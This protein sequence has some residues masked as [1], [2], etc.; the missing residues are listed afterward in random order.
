MNE[1]SWKEKFTWKPSE[2]R[3]C[4]PDVLKAMEA[5]RASGLPTTG[6]TVAELLRWAAEQRK[7]DGVKCEKAVWFNN[8]R[9]RSR[10]PRAKQADEMI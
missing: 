4:S 3:P 7:K 8:P 5:R 1:E 10:A 6:I 2:I 9:Q